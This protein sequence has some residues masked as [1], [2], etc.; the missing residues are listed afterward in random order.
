MRRQEGNVV[1]VFEQRK[2]LIPRR[3]LQPARMQKHPTHIQTSHKREGRVEQL[4]PPRHSLQEKRVPRSARSRSGVSRRN[5]V[6]RSVHIATF[7]EL[8]HSTSKCCWC[9]ER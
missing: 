2:R 3:D 4:Q 1:F 9:L 8:T 6:I 5:R 7:C